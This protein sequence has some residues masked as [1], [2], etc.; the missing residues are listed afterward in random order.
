MGKLKLWADGL[1]RRAKLTV[2]GHVIGWP[3]GSYICR[4]LGFDALDSF[5]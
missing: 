1:R 3:E 4:W 5:Q 2:R